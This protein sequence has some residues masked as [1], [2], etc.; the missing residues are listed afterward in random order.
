MKM[1]EKIVVDING[2]PHRVLLEELETYAY[3]EGKS[4][5]VLVSNDGELFNPLEKNHN[6]LKKDKERGCKFFNLSKCTKKCYEYY[7]SFLKSKNRVSLT[8]AQRSYLY[9]TGI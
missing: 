5:Y 8:I 3:T 9:E 6:R 4:H 1:N 7:L 2:T